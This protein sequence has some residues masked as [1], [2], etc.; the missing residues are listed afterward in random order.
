MTTYPRNDGVV[1]RRR[2]LAGS[3]GLSFGIA[4][5]GNA[6]ILFDALAEGTVFQPNGWIE[7]GTDNTITLIA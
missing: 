3:A 2:F 5:A 7:I 1:T 4:I 6:A